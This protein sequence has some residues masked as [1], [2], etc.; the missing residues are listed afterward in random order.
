MVQAPLGFE[1]LGPFPEGA[2]SCDEGGNFPPPTA[3]GCVGQG[4]DGMQARS[5]RKKAVSCKESLCT[6]CELGPRAVG[7]CQH[8]VSLLR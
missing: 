2:L 3:F 5:L 4:C 8:A 1:L 6:G 7:T